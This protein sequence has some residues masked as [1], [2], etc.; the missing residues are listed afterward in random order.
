MAGRDQ[1]APHFPTSK[2]RFQDP[3]FHFPTFNHIKIDFAFEERL[4]FPSSQGKCQGSHITI[5]VSLFQTHLVQIKSQKGSCPRQFHSMMACLSL[6]VCM[7]W[8]WGTSNQF[9]ISSLL[10]PKASPLCMKQ[11]CEYIQTWPHLTLFQLHIHGQY[12]LVW[13]ALMMV[14]DG[15]NRF[16]SLILTSS[17]PLLHL[18]ISPALC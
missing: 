13:R 12:K 10:C 11:H 15:K 1:L 7:P 8:L 3:L 14:I 18:P 16:Y 5:H 2:W 17:T 4:L 9:F 6:Q